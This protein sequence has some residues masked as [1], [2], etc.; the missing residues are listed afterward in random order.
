MP[1]LILCKG[2]TCFCLGFIKNYHLRRHLQ[3]HDKTATCQYCDVTFATRVDLKSHVKETHADEQ[4]TQAQQ[5]T[6]R[7]A[8]KSTGL[9]AMCKVCDRTYRRIGTLRAHLNQHLMTT[10][11][12]EVDIKT[13]LFLFN[14]L[15]IS[16]DTSTN[17]DLHQYLK[18]KIHENECENFYQIV[19]PDGYEMQLSDSEPEDDSEAGQSNDQDTKNF[20]TCSRCP[21][22]FKRSRD[23]QTHMVV[24]HFQELQSFVDKCMTCHKSFPN[25][26]T[27]HKHLKTQ[28]ANKTKK[29]SCSVCSKKFMWLNSMA[30][31]MEHEHPGA[32]KIKRH[33][34]DVCGKTFSRSQHLQRHRKIHF[35]NEKFDCPVC[36]KSYSRKDHLTA[37][38][39]RSCGFSDNRDEKA[40]HLCIYCGRS[41][42]NSWNYSVHMRT[43]TASI[44]ERWVKGVLTFC[45]YRA[46]SLS[47]ATDVRKST[48]RRWANDH[49]IFELVFKYSSFQ[50]RLKEHIEI[51]HMK[52]R[53]FVCNIC[54]AA[55]GSNNVLRGH[56]MI[57]QGVKTE[58]CDVRL[59][60][61]NLQYRSYWQLLFLSSAT[62]VSTQSLSWRSIWERIRQV[63][64][65]YFW[66]VY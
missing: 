41:F 33:S 65:G 22:T 64:S 44:S 13:K 7:T 10:T 66:E 56:L 32:E 59:P 37:H 24:D 23:S 57:H 9:I 26:Y 47:S 62:K 52:K 46:K 31:H 11:F 4:A 61:Y 28:C 40:N 54:G 29:L 21:K 50:S 45:P 58:K 25:P 63:L 55:F 39:K 20:Y 2:M 53:D 35:S 48:P 60:S 42:T 17:Q 34:C 15:E 27:L 6:D 30:R 16:L 1:S 12:D 8:T 14:P 19:T 38:M 5:K 51:I 43:H 18:R 3:T 36:Q 49:C